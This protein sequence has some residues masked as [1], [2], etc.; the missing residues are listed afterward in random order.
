MFSE[1]SREQAMALGLKRYFIGEPCRQGR[2]QGQPLGDHQRGRHEPAHLRDASDLAKKI[3]QAAVATLPSQ[4]L[5]IFET[6]DYSELIS[7]MSGRNI[8]LELRRNGK[9][10]VVS[11]GPQKGQRVVILDYYRRPTVWPGYV[12]FALREMTA[13]LSDGPGGPWSINR[14]EQTPI[15]TSK[16]EID[17]KVVAA[18]QAYINGALVKDYS[19][20]A[21][22]AL[23]ASIENAGKD[24]AVQAACVR[25]SNARL[26]L[27]RLATLFRSQ[28][29]L[30]DDWIK[31]L[32]ALPGGPASVDP[33][34]ACT[35]IL[36]AIAISRPTTG[37]N[38]LAVEFLRNWSAGAIQSRLTSFQDAYTA[39]PD[40]ASDVVEVTTRIDELNAFLPPQAVANGALVCSNGSRKSASG[41][42]I[43]YARC[44]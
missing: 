21:R 10:L 30:D 7:S 42:E 33:K 22:P 40:P 12:A 18:N 19:T 44:N 39:A 15:H 13:H 17:T 9:Q 28:L 5:G 14:Y 29:T 31:A 34:D 41:S 35:D 3:A 36:E 26:G 43:S 32:V 25:F 24:Q 1:H 37:P 16:D 11:Q 38:D 4:D 20:Q 6:H 23:I 2:G 8:N 27:M